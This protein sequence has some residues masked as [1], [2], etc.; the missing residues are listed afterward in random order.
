MV[1]RWSTQPTGSRAHLWHGHRAERG[2]EPATGLGRLGAVPSPSP[3]SRRAALG[4][5]TALTAALVSGCTA[6]RDRPAT[7]APD[8]ADDPD[9][10]LAATVLDEEQRMLDRVLATVRR[11][12]R[13][14]GALAGA[15][16]VHRRHVALLADAVPDSAASPSVP[17][18][19][20]PSGP[21]TDPPVVS[22]PERPGP[23]LAALARA[24]ERL[25]LVG[26]RSAF[27][28]ESGAFARVLASMAAAAAQQSVLLAAGAEDRG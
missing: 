9:V 6:S 17:A 28:A 19:A 14:D 27:T 26:R 20:S 15:R 23:A 24:E 18:D 4:G 7:A 22:V 21:A 5:A 8:G 13:L 25:S 1:V 3:L 2:A 10:P 12:P 11:H 16:A